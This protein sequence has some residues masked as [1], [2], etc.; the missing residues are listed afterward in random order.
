MLAVSAPLKRNVR[1]FMQIF[2]KSGKIIHSRGSIHALF[3]VLDAHEIGNVIV[4]VYDYMAFPSNEPAKNLFAY[5]GISGSE[6]WRGEDIGAG[7]TDG[8]TYIMSESPLV[9]GNFAGFDCTIDIKTGKIIS[10]AFTK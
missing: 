7:A 1:P 2:V 4:V 10:T 8:Y 6:L 3:P 9:V 5:S